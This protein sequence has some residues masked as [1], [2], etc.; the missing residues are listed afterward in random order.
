M[1]AGHT[2]ADGS[3]G[4]TCWAPEAKRLELVLPGPEQGRLNMERETGPGGDGWWRLQL[5]GIVPGLR[6]AYSVDGGPE[7]PDP[8]SHLQPEGVHGPSAVVDHAAFS[9]TD[10]GFRPPAFADWV[11]YELH[12]GTFTPGRDLFAAADRLPLLA[13]LGVTAVEVMPVAAFP[14]SRNWGYDGVA[15]YAVHAAYGGPEGLK[16]FVD[17]AHALGLA[18]ILDVVYNHLGPEGNY[19]REFGPYFTDSHHTPWGQAVNYDGPGSDGVRAYVVGN[20]LHWLSRYHLDGLRLD[21]VQTIHDESP[22]HILA[23]LSKAVDGLAEELGRPLRL[24]AESDANDPRLARSRE[25]GGYGCRAVWSDDLHHSLHALLTRETRGYY[26]DYGRASHAAEALEHGFGYRGAFSA[27]RGRSQGLPPDGLACAAHVVC[28]QNH[29]QVGN[30]MLGKRLC[31]L[32][33]LEAYKAAAACVLLSPFTPLLFM[34]EEWAADE[35][36]LYFVSHGDPDLVRAVRRGRRREFRAFG[37]RGQPPDPDAEETFARSTLDW[38]ARARPGHAGVLA[39]YKELLSLRRAEPF[40]TRTRESVRAFPVVAAGRERRAVCMRRAG[41]GRE[42]LLL[43]SFEKRL[44]AD[45]PSLLEG[46]GWRVLLDTGAAVFGGP[47][48][49]FPDSAPG[50]DAAR[51]MTLPGPR[52]LVLARDLPPY[53][54]LRQSPQPAREATP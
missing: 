6:Y 40:A 23:E 7:R 52:A 46:T 5:P 14:G 10:Q 15:P 42:A 44:A 32:T 27:F 9:W 20:A 39:C 28:L 41:G 24:I 12:A 38:E 25:L 2:F 43:A 34:G 29:D 51:R 18:V 4:F 21:A 1:R 36:F 3:C 35:P 19:L 33:D 26:R 8:A 50:P 11:I 17:A 16:A 45:F 47:G 53:P 49:V 31:A 30:R 22:R 13:E 48:A 54:S 37:W